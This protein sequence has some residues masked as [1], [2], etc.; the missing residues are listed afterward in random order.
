MHAISVHADS[1]SHQ[2]FSSGNL[3]HLHQQGHIGIANK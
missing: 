3:I 2:Y 1:E